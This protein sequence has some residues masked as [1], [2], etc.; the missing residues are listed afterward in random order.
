MAAGAG[1]LWHSLQGNLHCFLF[2]FVPCR[3]C[4]TPLIR[5]CRWIVSLSHN[6]VFVHQALKNG[7]QPVAIKVSCTW[8][9]T[10]CLLCPR[11]RLRTAKRPCWTV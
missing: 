10:R 11:N 9:S 2:A 3:V 1:L 7:V 8:L 5:S 6:L 4:E